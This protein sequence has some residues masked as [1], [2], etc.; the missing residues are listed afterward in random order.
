MRAGCF[1]QGCSANAALKLN[2]NGSSNNERAVFFSKGC[3]QS[4]AFTGY[5]VILLSYAK[6]N[7]EPWKGFPVNM[8]IY[9]EMEKSEFII[10]Q[11]FIVYLKVN[12]P[13]SNV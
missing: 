8:A 9:L 1:K 2:W 10:Y 3:K 5:D 12:C 7:R 6:K 4:E 13:F 11:T